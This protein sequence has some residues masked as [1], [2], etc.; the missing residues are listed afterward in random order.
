[1][2]TPSEIYDMINEVPKGGIF[3]I[4]VTKIRKFL[5]TLISDV[6]SNGLN[7]NT[8]II[9]ID[10]VVDNIEVGNEIELIQI[11]WRKGKIFIWLIIYVLSSSS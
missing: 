6:H 8:Y 5:Q 7:G 10:N 1:M 9:C 11:L 3:Q 4:G 2:I